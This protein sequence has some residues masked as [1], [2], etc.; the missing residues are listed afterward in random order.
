M[1]GLVTPVG[2]VEQLIAQ[3]ADSSEEERET[4]RH[5]ALVVLHEGAR[6]CAVGEVSVW[7]AV[8]ADGESWS[9]EVRGR[10]AVLL[11]RSV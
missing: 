2:A 9:V 4:L 6:G 11:Q 5:C 7:R 10:S 1:M 3:L 8:L